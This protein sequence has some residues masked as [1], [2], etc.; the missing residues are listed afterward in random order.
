MT[1]I[2]EKTP[3]VM[4]TTL[5]NPYNPFTEWNEW[6]AFDES[7]GYCTCG[8][9]ARIAKTSTDYTDDEVN[10]AYNEAI[11]EILKENILGIYKKVEKPSY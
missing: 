6:Y 5:D 7:A 4:L 2:D 9:I 1:S 11:D 3:E 8:Y 10:A